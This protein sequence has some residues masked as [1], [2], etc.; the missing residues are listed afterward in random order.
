MKKRA[1][2]EKAARRAA[3]KAAKD[4]GG[5]GSGRGRGGP[6][7]GESSSSIPPTNTQHQQK[8]GQKDSSKAQQHKRTPSQGL[9]GQ[10]SPVPFRPA[11]TTPPSSSA[12]AAKERRIAK[13]V[14][15]VGHLYSQPRRLTLEG[16]HKDVHPA[17]LALGFQMSNYVV[18]GSNARC[19]AMMLAFKKVILDLMSCHPAVLHFSTL[20]TLHSHF[21]CLSPS[22]RLYDTNNTTN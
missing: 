4:V 12:P 16:V 20:M 21:P 10:S 2:E 1:K 17:V 13:E 8:P 22:H 15:F 3:E 6:A 5:G 14:G 7:G 9:P 18:C 11:K 19:V